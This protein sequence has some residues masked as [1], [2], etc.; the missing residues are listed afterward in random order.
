[1]KKMIKNQLGKTAGKALSSIFF[2]KDGTTA[3]Y[4]RIIYHTEAIF[5]GKR[6][7]YLKILF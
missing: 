4:F 1:M 6:N 5:T 2:K 3:R 7:R